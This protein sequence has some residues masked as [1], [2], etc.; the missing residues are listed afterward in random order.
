MQPKI[1][2]H[3]PV[4]FDKT[5]IGGDNIADWIQ[6]EKPC[7]G[8]RTT[9]DWDWGA[10]VPTHLP[11]SMQSMT[12]VVAIG[13]DGKVAFAVGGFKAGTHDNIISKILTLEKSYFEKRLLA[14]TQLLSVLTVPGV[15]IQEGKLTIDWK[16]GQYQILDEPCLFPSFSEGIFVIPTKTVV[17]AMVEGSQRVGKKLT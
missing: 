9:K 11:H 6:D 10:Y 4:G 17:A 8:M 14:S 15:I 7:D 3:V 1:Q 13:C 5:R 2:R 12:Q 16:T